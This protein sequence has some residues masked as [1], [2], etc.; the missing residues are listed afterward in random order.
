MSDFLQSSP[1]RNR[2]YFKKSSALIIITFIASMLFFSSEYIWSK[3][4]G[5]LWDLSEN[6]EKGDLNEEVVNIINVKK[7]ET[8]GGILNRQELPNEDKNHILKLAKKEKSALN[9]QVGQEI[10]FYYNTEL[11]EQAESELVEKKYILDK[12]SIKTGKFTA[13]EFTRHDN[14]FVKKLITQPLKKVLVKY[15]TKVESSIIASLKKTGISNNCSIQLV[16]AYSHQIDLQRDIRSGDTITVIAEQ[17]VTE[18]GECSHTGRIVYALLNSKGKDY[19]I[20]LYSKN[21]KDFQFFNGQG[22][23]IQGTLLRTPVDVVRISSY[24]GYRK[25]HPVLGYGRMHKGVDYAASTGTPIYA[26]GA[27]TIE[28]IGWKK[29]YGRFILIKHKNNLSTAYAHASKF[30][31]GL[32]KGSK[33]PQ[34]KVIAYVGSTGYATG[35]HLHYEVRVNGKQVN[36]L[37]FKST[38]GIKLAG[39]DLAKF[40]LFKKNLGDISKKLS[41]KNN[42]NADILKIS[43]NYETSRNNLNIT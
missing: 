35:P 23:S 40:K 31:K 33:V 43:T 4:P 25:K 34:G 39:K 22:K 18:S 17:F 14:S 36:P 1:K 6:E 7:G 42:I 27:G 19:D 20:Y 37:K 28:F 26:S 12:M 8:L 30:A 9:L 3:L 16:K 11:I 38:P 24:F 5:T 13:T 15:E 2:R 21:N 10:T 32:K 29:G 41:K